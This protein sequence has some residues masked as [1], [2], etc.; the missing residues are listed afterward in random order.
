M[1]DEKRHIITHKDGRSYSVTKAA[2]AKVYEAQGF[3]LGDEETP[4]AFQ[5]VG[6]KAP[7]IRRGSPRA[8]RPARDRHASTQAL[9]ALPESAAEIEVD[10]QA[11]DADGG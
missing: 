4:A 6:V 10:G 3:K 5:V 7:A 1:A 9:G 8:K 11:A 2:F